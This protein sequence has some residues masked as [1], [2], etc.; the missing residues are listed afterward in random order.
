MAD[1]TAE[2]VPPPLMMTRSGEPWRRSTSTSTCRHCPQG[3]AFALGGV[4]RDGQRLDR[5]VGII[6]LRVEEQCPLGAQTGGIDLALEVAAVE[7]PAAAQPGRSAHTEFGIGGMCMLRGPLGLA[8]QLP[9]S[10]GEL[11]KRRVVLVIK[12][13]LLFHTPSFLG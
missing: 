12:Y 3:V 6:G 1:E 7:N 4:R 5:I 11:R 8:D 9:V 10:R 13:K 2:A